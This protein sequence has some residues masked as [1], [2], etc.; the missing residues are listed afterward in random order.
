MRAVNLLPEE[1]RG[2][3]APPVVTPATVAVGGTSLFLI[4]AVVVGVLYFHEHGRVSHR[5]DALAAVQK[6]IAVVQAENAKRAAA[7]S[8]AGS[9]A[10]NR[11]TAFDAAS[12]GRINWDN[13]LDDVSRVLPAGTWLNT[14]SMQ[15]GTATTPTTPTTTT[16]T[17]AAATAATA[18]TP[19]TTPLPTAFVI[20]GVALSQ[21]LVAKLMRRLALIPQL[22]TVTLQSSTR[23]DVG[24][25]KAFGF[26]VSANVNAPLEVAQ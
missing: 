9:N 17:G 6:Q 7:S 11:V 13:L 25:T 20:N 18:A 3:G 12:S 21:D 15:A 1:S 2:G 4:A 10:E 14:M 8:G 16:T 22:S 26:T 23:A 19:S 5:Q 24:K